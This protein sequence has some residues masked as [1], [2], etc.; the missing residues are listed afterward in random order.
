MG[1]TYSLSGL[2]YPDYHHLNFRRQQSQSMRQRGWEAR[3]K[4]I[5]ISPWKAWAFLFLIGLIG[6]MGALHV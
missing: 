3:M 1:R 6:L 4:P 5:F 2:F